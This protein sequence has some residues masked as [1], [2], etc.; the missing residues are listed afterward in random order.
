[1]KRKEIS[2]DGGMSK[3]IILNED[4]ENDFILIKGYEKWIKYRNG[5]NIETDNICLKKLIIYLNRH[6]FGDE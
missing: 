1:M 4:C 5:S 3:N 6:Y 2:Y